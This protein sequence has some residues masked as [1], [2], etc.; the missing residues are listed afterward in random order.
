MRG[1]RHVERDAAGV[2]EAQGLDARDEQRDDLLRHHACA[3]E[4]CQYHSPGN[5]KV[6]SHVHAAWSR[7]TVSV[8]F[9]L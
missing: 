3:P 7:E 4:V 9:F 1:T 8:F 5:R 6:P 2:E